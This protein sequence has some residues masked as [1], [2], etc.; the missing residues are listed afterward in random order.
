MTRT[1]KEK[2]GDILL[3]LAKRYTLDW[4][5]YIYIVLGSMLLA[6]TFQTFLLPNNIVAGGI[7]GL[8]I[9]THAVF[10]WN[11]A[12]FQYAMNIP[13]LVL[14]FI[15][16]GKE[17]GYKTI[18]G[19]LLVPF[20]LQFIQHLE[21]AT[22]DQLLAT[23]FGGSFTGLGLGMVF[24]SKSSTG[25]TSILIQ[26]LYQMLHIPLGAGTLL[27][28]GAVIFTALLAFNVEIVMY[29]MISLFLMSRVIDFVQ[30]GFRR[31]KNVMIISDQIEPIRKEI[32]HTL[33]RGVTSLKS[34]GGYKESE[35][36]VLMT[37]I[38]EKEF[39]VLKEIISE[40][41]PDAFVVAMGAS[42]VLGR[43]FS[44]HKYFPGVDE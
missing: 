32:L 16:L 6:W 8:S 7:S 19:S 4:V 23:I 29:S 40:L 38:Q 22:T 11:P 1:F 20:F 34:R 21:P 35:N 2:E 5:D 42:E 9:V 43:G 12:Y 24:R 41:D 28:D 15:V 25:G 30:M 27:I 44:L 10:G 39:P 3:K 13:L 18:L 17:V 37:V 31:N 33:D 14:C 36:E 26:I